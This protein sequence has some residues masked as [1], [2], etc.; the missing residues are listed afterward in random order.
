MVDTSKR[1][2]A[3]SLIRQFVD[4]RISNYNYDSDFPD[5]TSDQGLLAIYDRLWLLYSDLALSRFDKSK[6]TDEELS[7]IERCVAFLRTDLEYEGPQ[8]RERKPFDGLKSLWGRL[9]SPQP[10]S[11]LGEDAERDSVFHSGW[12]PF[13]SEGQY[14]ASKE[15]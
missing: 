4:G 8:L 2:Q 5:D 6:L 3:A 13:A 9:V 11:A 12:W 15:A 7:V 10:E 14:L 1:K